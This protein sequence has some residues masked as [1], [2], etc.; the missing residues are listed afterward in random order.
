M[1][2]RLGGQPGEN[3]VDFLPVVLPAILSLAP[4]I[5][6]RG[7]KTCV[8][9]CSTFSFFFQWHCFLLWFLEYEIRMVQHRK[10]FK[11]CTVHYSPS[12]CDGFVCVRVWLV[13]SLELNVFSWL[14]KQ[15]KAVSEILVFL[16]VR[17]SFFCFYLYF[18]FPRVYSV[19]EAG[20]TFHQFP[21]WAHWA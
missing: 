8:D 7:R 9:M 20:G 13:L 18:L 16:F 11:R 12:L 6:V 5:F 17:H 2:F 19:A 1:L 10:D 14:L 15:V 3:E 4:F 21:K